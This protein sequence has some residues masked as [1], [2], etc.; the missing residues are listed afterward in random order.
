[1]QWQYKWR[2]AGCAAGISAQGFG[3][4]NHRRLGLRATV[5]IQQA[6]IGAF[7]FFRGYARIPLCFGPEP[8]MI[9]ESSAVRPLTWHILLLIALFSRDGFF[10]GL[11]VYFYF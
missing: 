1:V 5:D 7:P 4:A 11:V 10:A 9:D 2:W 6:L 8:M 3:R